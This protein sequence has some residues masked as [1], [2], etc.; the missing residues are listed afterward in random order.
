M[1][2]GSVVADQSK[3][4]GSNSSNSAADD[5]IEAMLVGAAKTVGLLAWWAVRFPLA[6]TPIVV[7]L[8][9][10]VLAGWR[11]GVVVVV[12]CA[13]GYGL[14]CYLDRESFHRV[15]WLP[16]AESWLT[17]WRYKRSWEQVCTL[18]R[19]TA[20]L[21]DRTLIPMLRS[22]SIGATSDVLAVRIV[23]GQCVADWQKQRRRAGRGVARPAGDDPLDSTGRHRDHRASH[24]RAGPSDATAAA[25]QRRAKSILVVRWW[26]SPKLGGGG[27]CRC[28]A[29]T[30]SSPAPPG[31]VRAAW[32]GR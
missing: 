32:C 11:L 10:T 2:R 27:H 19:L 21:G 4:R 14:W 12:V 8:G 22:V 13:I 9:A 23:T 29:T 7:A 15:V 31:L 25:G 18:H 1:G 30:S 17:W 16:M 28:W 20:T 24:R 26:V 5:L 3:S 6:S